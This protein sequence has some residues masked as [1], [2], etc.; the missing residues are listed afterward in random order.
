M[1]KIGMEPIRKRQLIE[2]TI[3][4]IHAYGFA[5]T[6]IATISREAGVSPGIIHHYFGGK[7]ALLAATMQALLIEWRSYVVAALRAADGPKARIEAIIDASFAERQFQPQVIVTWLAFWG[8]APHDAMLMRLQRL[9]ANRL[10]SNLRYDLRRLVAPSRVDGA[11]L[12]LAA[13]I[14]G[15]WLSCA[16]GHPGLGAE[17]ARKLAKDYLHRQLAEKVDGELA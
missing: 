8:Q 15:L 6:T 9:Y 10:K 16:L 3:A 14:D 13:L 2:A 4:S 12:G 17:A 11:T 1:P 7:G 5:D